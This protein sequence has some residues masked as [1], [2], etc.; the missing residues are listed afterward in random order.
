MSKVFIRG[1]HIS[2]IFF[3]CI[4][5]MWVWDIV[6]TIGVGDHFLGVFTTRSFN[7]HVNTSFKYS[8][9]DSMEQCQDFQPGCWEALGPDSNPMSGRVGF[10]YLYKLG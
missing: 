4:S 1:V 6:F 10:R 9:P 5:Y 8:K 7:E 2:E 3:Q